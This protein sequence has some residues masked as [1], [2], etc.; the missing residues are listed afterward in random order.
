M[1]PDR[2]VANELSVVDMEFQFARATSRREYIHIAAKS[3][4]IGD[5][6]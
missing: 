5:A 3:A 2:S 6:D 1:C 4:E